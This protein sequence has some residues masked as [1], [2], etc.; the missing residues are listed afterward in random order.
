MVDIEKTLQNALALQR[1]GKQKESIKLL[2]MSL[3]D[4]PKNSQVLWLLGTGYLSLKDY[5]RSA[6]YLAKALKYDPDNPEILN[7]KG[8]LLLETNEY[9]SAVY[10]FKKILSSQPEN[11]TLLANLS[12]ALKHQK[13]FEEALICARK[14]HELSN[15]HPLYAFKLANILADLDRFDEAISL[16]NQATNSEPRYLEAWVNLGN[17]L[18]IKKRFDEAKHAYERALIVEPNSAAIKFNLGL[19]LLREGDSSRGWELYEARRELVDFKDNGLRRLRSPY[20]RGESL[21]GKTILVYG[22]QGRGDTLQYCRYL[23]W[24][25]D[26]GASQVVLYCDEK[27]R[28]LLAKLDGVDEWVNEGGV[29]PKHHFHVSIMS[30]PSIYFSKGDLFHID[31]PYLKADTFQIERWES[32][33][34]GMLQKAERKL[35][36]GLVWQGNPG[37]VWDKFRSIPLKYLRP[38]IEDTSF[39]IFS[40]QVFDPT[41]QL[42]ELALSDPKLHQELNDPTPQLRERGADYADTAGLLEHIDVVVTTDTSMV[43]LCAGLGKPTILLLGAYADWRYGTD[44]LYVDDYPSLRLCREDAW[45]DWASAVTKAHKLLRVYATKT[46]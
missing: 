26:L 25:K 34:S 8:M 9:D 31:H 5:Q 22:E 40:L 32:Y 44:D 37:F 36:V 29:V 16:L 11:Y 24:L 41:N 7:A 30:L 10:V 45:G 39:D 20:W 6:N 23:S 46:F 18:K 1:S 17:Y 13:Q 27:M 21:K 2:K 12:L 42:S 28:G 15:E 4:S 35:R 19:L 3:K 43:H 14:A 38:I 33:F